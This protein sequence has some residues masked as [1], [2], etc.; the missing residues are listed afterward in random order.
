MSIMNGTHKLS[1]SSI[2]ISPTQ[3]KSP[4]DVHVSSKNKKTE[5]E[6]SHEIVPTM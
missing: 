4:R 1:R 5:Y 3:N 2:K 6:M